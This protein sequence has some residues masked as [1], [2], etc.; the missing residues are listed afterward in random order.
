MAS[1]IDSTINKILD[2]IIMLNNERVRCIIFVTGPGGSGKSTFAK[3]LQSKL[4]DCSILKL[5]DYRL[6]RD[7]R[8]S[9]GL[10]GSN[11]SANNIKVI[12]EHLQK[13]RLGE[14]FDK[15]IYNQLTGETD[16][17]EIYQPV[18]YNLIDG[19]LGLHSDLINHA[20][21][22]IYLQ[23]SLTKQLFRRLNRDLFKRKYSL[24]K[25]INVF[26]QSNL[27][28]FKKYYKSNVSCANIIVKVSLPNSI[29]IIKGF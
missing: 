27:Q 21:F 16:K 9:S 25:S 23:L 6:S 14:K 15:P 12:I 22:I 7:E 26:W 28:D 10:F 1:D 18:K 17:K 5:D 2:K 19:E 24:L 20:D 8:I 4:N 29:K 13:I 11:P 3:Q